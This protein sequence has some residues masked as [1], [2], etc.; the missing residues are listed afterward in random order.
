MVRGLNDTHDP[1]RKSWV[2]SANSASSD[3]PLQNIPHGVFSAPGR[4]RRGG[5]AIG[6]MVLDLRAAIDSDLISGSVREVAEAAAA[7]SLN[8]LLAMGNDAASALH[9]CLFDMLADDGATRHRLESLSNELLVPLNEAT[10][11]KPAAIGAFTDFMTSTYH[12]S[13]ARRARPARELSENFLHLPLGYNSRASSI[14]VDGVPF[15]RPFGQHRAASGEIVFAPTAQLD[16]EVEFGA[17]VGQG[18][19]LGSRV[20]LDDAEKHI[21]GYVLVNDWS[22]RDIQLWEMRVGPFLG[23]SFCTSISPWIVTAEAMAPFRRAPYPRSAN[24]PQPM[25]HLDSSTHRLNGALDV[26]LNAFISTSR[27]RAA[28]QTSTQIVQTNLL[29]TSWTLAQMLTHHTTNGCN[30]QPGDLLGSGT[31]SGPTEDS[32]ACLLE[33]TAGTLPIKLPNGE[34]RTWLEDGDELIIKGRAER[35]GF[36]AI[37]FGSC[38]ARVLPPI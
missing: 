10:L 24:Q 25:P 31:V 19:Q 13:A 18:N 1:Q 16:F 12:A 23:K 14:S 21:F 9:R 2:S 37:G 36:A 35:E 3:F 32:A 4:P 6:D 26:K 7:P 8:A 28:G 15:A 11:Y 30:L 17:L 33:I 20:S 27:M 29:H 5:V 22:A 34:Y 38:G